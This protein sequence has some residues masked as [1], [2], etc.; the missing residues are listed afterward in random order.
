MRKSILRAS[1]ML[2]ILFVALGAAAWAAARHFQPYVRA[3]AIRYLEDSFGTGVELGSFRVSVSVGS[4]WKLETAVVRVSGDRLALPYPRAAGLP[5]LIKVGKFRLHS[6]LSA[7][8][9]PQRP[10][11]EIQLE[12]VEINIPPREKRPVSPAG[13]GPVRSDVGI[14]VDEIQVDGMQLCILASDPA[15]QARVFEI[16]QLRFQSIGADRPLR[17]Q[18]TLMNPT[19]PGHIEVSGEFGPWQKDD[20]GLTTVSGDYQFRRADL[21]VFRHIAGILSSTGRFHG[22]LRRLEVDGRT[23]TPDFRLTGGNPVPLTTRFHSIVDGTSGDTSLQPVDATLGSSRLSAR[24][25]VIRPR[26]AKRGAVALDVVMTGGR[27][28]D[29]LLLSV[30]SPQPLMRGEIGLRTK[31]E[32]LPQEQAFDERLVLDGTFDVEQALFTGVSIQEKID[33]LSRRAQGKPK[34]QEIS[35]M[36]SYI[37][38]GFNLRDGEIRFSALTFQVQGAAVHLKGSYGLDSEQIDLHGVARLRAKLSQTMTGWKRIALK[39]ADPFFSKAGAGTLLPIKVTG[40][41]EKPEFGLD[42][43]AKQKTGEKTGSAD[44]RLANN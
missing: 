9:R 29:L 2:A 4:L 18:A 36:L 20:P 5:P 30:K 11:R 16:H 34:D 43:V 3:L 17:Y 35:E 37:G 41:R 19:P 25:S 42:R 40:T 38:G 12:E 8:W 33:S 24:G 7:L 23:E 1:V 31:M 28:E 21:A 44:R 27:I 26:G 39:P 22:V 6:A 10:I 14:S 13:N 15:K 32:I